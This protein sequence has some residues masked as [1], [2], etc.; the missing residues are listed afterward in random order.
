MVNGYNLNDI[1]DQAD[2]AICAGPLGVV[3]QDFRLIEKKT[4]YENIERLPCGPWAPP[5]S[6]I[7]RRIPYVLES[8]GPGPARADQL[9]TPALRRRAAAGGHRP[10]PGQQP[11][12]HHRRRAHG[13]P[14]PGQRSLEIMI[15]AGKDQ[16]HGHHHPGGHPR[17][18]SWSTASPSAWWPSR[19]AASSATRQGGITAMGDRQIWISYPGGLPE[20]LHPWA[21]VLRCRVH[22]RWPVCSSWAPSPCIAVNAE[23]RPRRPGKGQRI[24]GLHR[25]QP[26]QRTG[27]RPCKVRS[28][29][30]PTWPAPPL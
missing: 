24:S 13:Q 29:P 25:R 19:A 12:R 21:D 9:P 15:A 28:R 20:Y 11:Q 3:F 2:P 23:P 7:R 1:S 14:G 5:P 6:E 4:V 18:R 22:D 10:G 16:R 17:A 26:D 8:G 27:P 30:F